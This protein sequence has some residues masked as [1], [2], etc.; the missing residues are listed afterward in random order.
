MTITGI[1]QGSYTYQVNGYNYLTLSGPYSYLGTT[2]NAS[3]S[4]ILTAQSNSISVAITNIALTLSALATN[5]TTIK[6]VYGLIPV[7]VVYGLTCTSSTSVVYTT[8]STPTSDC[9]S[10]TWLGDCSGSVLTCSGWM[11]AWP[12]SAPCAVTV[13]NTMTR[14]GLPLDTYHV[15]VFAWDLSHNLVAES[16]VVTVTL[17]VPP[18]MTVSMTMLQPYNMPYITLPFTIQ[19]NATSYRIT[20]TCGNLV[21]D[22]DQSPV[23]LAGLT[24][25]PGTF[26]YIVTARNTTG[27]STPSVPTSSIYIPGPTNVSVAIRTPTTATLTFTPIQDNTLNY[28]N[29]EISCNGNVFDLVA[30]STITS[31]PFPFDPTQTNAISVYPVGA[32][33]LRTTVLI[34]SDIVTNVTGTSTSV[35]VSFVPP[36]NGN[37]SYTM[38][39]IDGSGTTMGSANGSTSPITISTSA[40]SGWYN[41]YLVWQGSEC[42][43]YSFYVPP[44]TPSVTNATDI[45]QNALIKTTWS[46]VPDKTMQSLTLYQLTCTSA[47]SSVTYMFPATSNPTLSWTSPPLLFGTLYTITVIATT[48]SITTTMTSN[49]QNI[50]TTF[51]KSITTNPCPISYYCSS[52]TAIHCP[53]YTTSTNAYAITDC[54]SLTSYYFNGQTDLSATICP[55][56][57]YCPAA[58][59][60]A[61]PCPFGSYCPT[62]GL[63]LGLPCPS[64]NYCPNV[65]MTL[66]LPCTSGMYCPMTGSSTAPLCPTYYY[67]PT[68]MS[69][70]LCPAGSYCPAGSTSSTLCPAGSYC[71]AYIETVVYN[72]TNEIP[73]NSTCVAID[74][75]SNTIYFTSDQRTIG[76]ISSAGVVSIFYQFPLVYNNVLGIAVDNTGNV[77]CTDGANNIIKITSTGTSSTFASG[78]SSVQPVETS[79]GIAVDSNGYVYVANGTSIHKINPTTKAISTIFTSSSLY[80]PNPLRILDVAVDLTGN[81]YASDAGNNMIIKIT[82]GGLVSTFVSGLFTKPIGISVDPSG[83]VYV[84]VADTGVNYIRKIYPDGTV[85]TPSIIGTV[86]NA[87]YLLYGSSNSLAINGNGFIYTADIN[88]GIKKLATVGSGPMAIPC[89]A[90]YYCP[91]GSINPIVC[92]AGSSCP[93]GSVTPNVCPAGNFCPNPSTITSCLAGAYNL[94][95]NSTLSTD[96]VTCPIGSYCPTTST[97]ATCPAGT[98]SLITGNTS[99]TA[100]PAGSYCPNS[101]TITSCPVGT[102]NSTTGSST[103]SSCVACSAGTY[104]STTGQT[105][106]S[107]C[108]VGTY[109]AATGQ[110]SCLNCPIGTSSTT[111]GSTSLTSCTNCAAGTYN[112]TA[113]G[114]CKDCL[115]G[116]A[117][118]LVGQTSCPACPTG[119]YCPSGSTQSSICPIYNYCPTPA[120][121]TDCVDPQVC[122]AGNTTPLSSKTFSYNGSLQ[123]Y[124]VPDGITQLDIVISGSCGVSATFNGITSKGGNGSTITLS[125]KVTPL[126]VLFLVVGGQNN[127]FGGGMGATGTTFP[128]TCVGSNGGDY[129]GI[130][131]NVSL[132]VSLIIAAG[133]G[134]GFYSYGTTTTIVASYANGGNGST[135][136]SGNGGIGSTML[137]TCINGGGGTRSLGGTSTS[138]AG[139]SLQGGN[140]NTSAGLQGGGGGGGYYG[141]GAGSNGA[142]GGGSNFVKGYTGSS[143]SYTST[144]ATTG[145]ITITPQY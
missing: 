76:K 136:V 91:A 21:T 84:A 131:T 37:S 109:N 111:T 137:G 124:T 95:T 72:G 25:K 104:N 39:V 127:K 79:Y 121:I 20:D 30:T 128:N 96:C 2:T 57:N 35:V 88:G 117:N 54:T 92:P 4:G 16:T 11:G 26:S 27:Q 94:K 93:V 144:N 126:Q 112:N 101:T 66:P 90:G 74:K 82:S 50:S 122:P 14:S 36:V 100:C 62:S 19:S 15:Q 75:L 113:G 108:S 29:Y 71:S 118:P 47:S 99:C 89:P 61:T 135:S 123:S 13:S 120:T 1:N 58:S 81:V 10:N 80:H 145:S 38:Y 143:P 55:S 8:Y 52:T 45:N 139:L 138:G 115:A 130:F 83:N 67:C 49:I 9:S 40:L 23:I 133:G 63:G 78:I 46:T 3:L 51:S 43:P 5:S 105:S 107:A 77:Y 114:S 134:G 17:L 34:L 106:C 85:V 53:A 24:I 12:S 97:I 69:S 98:T 86:P 33:G 125:I 129:S 31:N 110:T 119:T 6:G 42:L 132:S 48:V 87:T 102:Y 64:G 65:R 56:G 41:T 73:F 32:P 7:G 103:I 18:T 60:S 59:T 140:S 142:G 70:I 116:T 68:T 44:L 141:G 22:T 28:T